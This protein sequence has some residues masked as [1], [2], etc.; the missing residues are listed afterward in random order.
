MIERNWTFISMNFSQKYHIAQ[1]IQTLL[2]QV[3][4]NIMIHSNN[5]PPLPHWLTSPI[6]TRTL[7]LHHQ[8]PS[9]YNPKMIHLKNTSIKI[10]HTIKYKFSDESSRTYVLSTYCKRHGPMAAILTLN[11]T[12]TMT[13]NKGGC[14]KERLWEHYSIWIGTATIFSTNKKNAINHIHT[15]NYHCHHCPQIYHLQWV[16][17]HWGVYSWNYYIN[18]S[19]TAMD[20]GDLMM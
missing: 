17:F 15:I 6:T 9:Y 7:I 14:D 12:T 10:Y 4:V 19:T 3:C 11:I 1:H 18:D 5:L 16:Y 2:Y 20:L 8:L 13:S